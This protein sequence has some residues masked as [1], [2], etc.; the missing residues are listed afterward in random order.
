MHGGSLH[1]WSTAVKSIASRGS[2]PGSCSLYVPDSMMLVAFRRTDIAV[3]PPFLKGSVAETNQ[4]SAVSRS[5]ASRTA[6]K[7]GE[8]TEKGNEMR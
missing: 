1:V 7:G 6:V 2:I 5:C 3:C 8:K 4:E